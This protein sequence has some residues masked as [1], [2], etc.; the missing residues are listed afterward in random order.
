MVAEKLADK[1]FFRYHVPFYHCGLATIF[2][3]FKE[4]SPLRFL[5]EMLNL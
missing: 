3:Y 1:T 5:V 2:F 4:K